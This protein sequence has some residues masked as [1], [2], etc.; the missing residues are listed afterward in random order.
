MRRKD[1]DKSSIPGPSRTCGSAARV[2]QLSLSAALVM[3][4]AASTAAGGT[5]RLW[6]SAVVV[7]ES[8]RLSDLC[9]LNGFAPG[10]GDKLASVAVAAAPPSG[11]SRVVHMD[12]VRSA[13]AQAGA[14]MATIELRGSTRCEVS[15]PAIDAPPRIEDSDSVPT[16]GTKH[17]SSENRAH[18]PA[19]SGKG[20]T[21]RLQDAVV[22]YFD[23]E[24]SRIGGTADVVFDHTSDQVLDLS[25]PR[26]EFKVRRRGGSLPGIAPIEVD[27]VTDGLV[28]QTVPMVVQVRVS[29]GRVVARRSINQGATIRAAD[30]DVV[31]T[32][33]TRIEEPG[34]DGV[35]QVVGQRAKKFLPTGTILSPEALESVPLVTRGDLVTLTSVAG[36]VQVVTTARAAGDGGLGDV[37]TVRAVDDKRVEFDATVVGPGRVRIGGGSSSLHGSAFAYGGTR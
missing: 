9:E 18:V 32:I 26:Y 30:V 28:V 37:I 10:T 1:Y 5:I 33:V 31:P 13:V 3:G 17:T 23:A 12:M 24:F 19:V 6:P 8:V 15:R 22:A 11:G 25:G 2:L 36:N 14:N 29:A 16:S 21:L 7:G 35:A 4:L 20:K 27:V 34:F